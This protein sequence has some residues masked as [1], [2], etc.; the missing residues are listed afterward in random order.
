MR[1]DVAVV[2]AVT[3]AAAIDINAKLPFISGSRCCL[4]AFEL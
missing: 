3:T 4:F 1:D 2:V